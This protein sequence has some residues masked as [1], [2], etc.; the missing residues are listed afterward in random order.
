MPEPYPGLHELLDAMIEAL[1]RELP[2]MRDD[3]LSNAINQA[4]KAAAHAR[5]RLDAIIAAGQRT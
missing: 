2:H 4:S 3:E 1:D 5:L